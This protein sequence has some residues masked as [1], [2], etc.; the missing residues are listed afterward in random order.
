MPIM[1]T[2]VLNVQLDS[3]DAQMPERQ[4]E[5]DAGYD[6]VATGVEY[7]DKYG[8]YMYDTGV[9]VE[10]PEGHVGMIAP[11]S[12]IYKR[13]LMLANSVGVIDRGYRGEIK[14]LFIPIHRTRT[15][16]QSILTQG[17][18][19]STPDRSGMGIGHTPYEVGER[20]AQLLLMPVSTPETAEKSSLSQSE[21]GEEGF[22]STGDQ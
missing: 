6:L 2:N 22:G 1:N 11:R 7:K 16:K 12:S 19:D 13:G 10:I 18:P 3:Q 4:N 14:V 21:R 17:Q 9:H 8:I 5:G 20:I 15:S